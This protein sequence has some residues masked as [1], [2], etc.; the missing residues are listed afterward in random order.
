[1]PPLAH[2]QSRNQ[3]APDCGTLIYSLDLRLKSTE[4]Y[5]LN[6]SWMPTSRYAPEPHLCENGC[7]TASRILAASAALTFWAIAE[8]W[9]RGCPASSVPRFATSGSGR[10]KDV[11][12]LMYR[13]IRR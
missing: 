4:P 10:N 12:Y 13:Q 2:L 11:Q 3:Y 5:N 1:M 9:K 6:A 7:A 8:M